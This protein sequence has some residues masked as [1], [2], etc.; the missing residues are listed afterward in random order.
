MNKRRLCISIAENI[1]ENLR[2]KAFEKRI[3]IS[4]YIENLIVKKDKIQ[5][6]KK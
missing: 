6:V 1:Y 3:S 2:I 5:D 4:Q